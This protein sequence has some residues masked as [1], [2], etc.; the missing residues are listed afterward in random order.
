MRL[1]LL[2]YEGY[3]PGEIGIGGGDYIRMDICLDC[4]QV[5]GEFP[6]AECLLP[7]EE[8]EPIDCG[9]DED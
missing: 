1:G 3:V 7:F 5:Q 8:G 6:V 9:D 2:T 4:G